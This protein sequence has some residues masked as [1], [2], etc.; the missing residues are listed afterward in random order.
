MSNTTNTL[1]AE[2]VAETALELGVRGMYTQL[3]IRYKK[4]IV[5]ALNASRRHLPDDIMPLLVHLDQ[6]QYDRLFELVREW[7][8]SWRMERS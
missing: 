7:Y 8:L 3:P 6:K 1:L 2:E 5:E 4:R